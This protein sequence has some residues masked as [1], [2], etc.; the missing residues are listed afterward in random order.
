[1]VRR[2]GRCVAANF[3][4]T[5]SE[6]AVCLSTVGI[7]DRCDRSTLELRGS[8]RDVELALTTLAPLRGRAWFALITPGT[9]IVRCE[10]ADA[11]ECREAMAAAA[12]VTVHERDDRFAAIGVIGPCA[13]ELVS[14]GAWQAEETP[15]IVVRETD[16]SFEMLVPV[17][18]GPVTWEKLLELGAPFRIACVGMDA[19]EHL[20]ASH[21]LDRTIATIRF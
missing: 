16:T 2:H 19:L 4:S 10:S 13:K 17:A 21:R 20:A 1:M 14:G 8:P 6:A 18:H 9:A 3:G 15:P 12:G 5:T 11:P 7:A